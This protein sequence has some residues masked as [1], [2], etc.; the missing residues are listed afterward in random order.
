MNS[1]KKRKAKITKHLD[2]LDDVTRELTAAKNTTNESFSFN[3]RKEQQQITQHE[4]KRAWKHNHL[5]GNDRWR[6]SGVKCE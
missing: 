4:G 3:T 6:G 2:F 1:Y 5:K